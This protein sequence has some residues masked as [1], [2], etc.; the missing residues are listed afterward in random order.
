M[1]DMI[2]SFIT[3]F[4]VMVSNWQITIEMYSTV[5]QS[6]FIYVYFVSF[7]F[8][9]VIIILNI[10]VAFTIDVYLKITKRY[11]LISNEHERSFKAL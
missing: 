2:T 9:S 10:L 8:F 4:C 6:S 5:S 11:K 7:Y 1:N 3:L